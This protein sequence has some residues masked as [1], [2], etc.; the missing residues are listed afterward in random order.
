MFPPQD[1]DHDQQ[2]QTG[3][4]VQGSSRTDIPEKTHGPLL[5]ARKLNEQESLFICTMESNAKKLWTV[6]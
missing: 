3:K 5:D 6:M 2:Q 4:Q 1:I